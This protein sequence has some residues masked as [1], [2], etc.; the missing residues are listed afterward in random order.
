MA[1]QSEY[2]AK[3]LGEIEVKEAVR[4]SIFNALNETTSRSYQV[5][6]NCSVYCTFTR[7]YDVKKLCELIEKTMIR[8]KTTLRQSYLFSYKECAELITNELIACEFITQETLEEL[9][10]KQLNENF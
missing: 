1:N 6:K 8:Y 2:T 10:Q 4:A 3:E 7:E 5:V 9:G